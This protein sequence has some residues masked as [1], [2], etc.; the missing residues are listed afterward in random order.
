MTI[1]RSHGWRHRLAVACTCMVALLFCVSG[2]QANIEARSAILLDAATGRVLYEQDADKLI[3]PA[4]LT[5]VLSMFVVLDSVKAGKVSLKSPVRVSRKAAGQGG[6]RMHL[7][8]REKVALDRILMGM[9]VSSGNDA[10]VA[11]AECVA[12]SEERFVQ[13]M[14]QKMRQLG[15]KQS[16]FKNAHGL[17]A[18]GQRTTAREM[19][20]L[21]Y[22]Y[23]KK[24]PEALRYHRSRALRHNGIVTTNKNPLL[25]VCTGADGLKTGW[26]TASGYN[27]I[28]TVKRGN[29]RLLAVIMGA[30]S[31]LVR[32]QEVRRLM[33]SGFYAVE[34]KTTVASALQNFPS[35][36]VASSSSKEGLS[37]QSSKKSS[38]KIASGA[39]SKRKNKKASVQTSRTSTKAVAQ[40]TPAK[41]KKAVAAKTSTSKSK[42]KASA[43]KRTPKNSVTAQAVPK[44]VASQSSGKKDALGSGRL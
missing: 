38:K 16:V 34:K 35:K 20:V 18:P 44:P 37:K 12:G 11:A 7:K 10:S 17:P 27:I 41:K 26:I 39:S 40:K 5:K 43:S 33:E 36:Y 14:T 2:A 24:Y 21:S 28:S 23:L 29:T 1:A 15:L 8:A 3:A 4:S 31:G 32:S 9:A 30:S 25:D 42:N 19:A 13:L 6:S 22:Q